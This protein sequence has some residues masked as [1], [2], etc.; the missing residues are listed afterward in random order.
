MED[1]GSSLNNESL[2]INPSILVSV[3]Q[4]RPRVV[5]KVKEYQRYYSSRDPT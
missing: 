5:F 2:N 1:S 4:D 3:T